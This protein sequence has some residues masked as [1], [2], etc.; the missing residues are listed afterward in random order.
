ML[1]AATTSVRSSS[2]F[3]PTMRTSFASTSMRCE[4]AEVVAAV[5]ARLGPRPPAGLA[6]E[7]LQRLR[8][9]A[10]PGPIERSSGPLRVSA[11]L[12]ADAFSSVT[13]SLRSARLA[14]IGAGR[15]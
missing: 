8:R 7:G 3:E 4:C 6:R 2:L 9:D 11:G 10:R 12:V 14:D 1:E 5:A 13:R 15:S